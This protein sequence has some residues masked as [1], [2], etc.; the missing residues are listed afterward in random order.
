M[1]IN[2]IPKGIMLSLC[3]DSENYLNRREFPE[4]NC[5]HDKCYCE[6]VRARVTRLLCLTLYVK[7]SAPVLSDPCSSPVLKEMETIVFS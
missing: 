2:K 4:G 3:E 5:I 6:R 7:T 1:D